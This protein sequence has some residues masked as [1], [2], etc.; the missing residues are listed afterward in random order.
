MSYDINS[1][2]SDANACKGKV[3]ARKVFEFD[4]KKRCW[5]LTYT[6][7]DGVE[8]TIEFE[9][10]KSLYSKSMHLVHTELHDGLN[11]GVYLVEHDEASGNDVR[12]KLVTVLRVDIPNLWPDRDPHQV[13]SRNEMYELYEILMRDTHSTWFQRLADGWRNYACNK[14]KA[15]DFDVSFVDEVETKQ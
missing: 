9:F 12:T 4:K 2:V 3:D 11:V 1:A 10:E 13:I 7:W 6:G 15:L 8:R 5:R 14:S